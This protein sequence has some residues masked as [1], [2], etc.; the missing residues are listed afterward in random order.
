MA[1]LHHG[2]GDQ[3]DGHIIGDRNHHVTASHT[4]LQLLCE[5]HS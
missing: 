4:K 1:H 5:W 2:D 3:H